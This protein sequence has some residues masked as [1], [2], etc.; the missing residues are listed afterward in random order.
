MSTLQELSLSRRGKR[1][2]VG[3]PLE[4]GYGDDES[5]EYMPA[6]TW[7]LV[8]TVLSVIPTV[9]GVSICGCLDVF[10]LGFR[11]VRSVGVDTF[12]LCRSVL[13]FEQRNMTKSRFHVK[14]RARYLDSCEEN[15]RLGRGGFIPHVPCWNGV[16]FVFLLGLC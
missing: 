16:G 6:G 10:A 8:S 4:D 9:L 7:H 11:G 14:K 1:L 5:E 2:I 3:N 15:A 13:F 12:A